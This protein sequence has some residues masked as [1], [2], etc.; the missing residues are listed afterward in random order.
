MDHAIGAFKHR[1]GI[2]ARK[3]Q[4]SAGE[5]AHSVPARLCAPRHR[6]AQKPARA[7]DDKAQAHGAGSIGAQRVTISRA[8][9]PS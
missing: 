9:A 2:V 6:A 7:G 3:I 1:G 8:P 4:I 5:R